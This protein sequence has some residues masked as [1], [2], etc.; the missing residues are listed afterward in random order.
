MS[1]KLIKVNI[2]MVTVGLTGASILIGSWILHSIIE[3][4]KINNQGKNS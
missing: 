3:R 4:I 1:D 2:A